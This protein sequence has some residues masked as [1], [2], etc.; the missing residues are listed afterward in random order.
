VNKDVHNYTYVC[1][2]HYT[3]ACSIHRVKRSYLPAAIAT[4]GI[5]FN[6]SVCVSVCV[7]KKPKS[8]SG[9][10]SCS[11]DHHVSGYK[12]IGMVC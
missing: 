4:A 10:M 7:S 2:I 1:I 5:V 6:A 3:T 8:G 12:Y 11:V 9:E